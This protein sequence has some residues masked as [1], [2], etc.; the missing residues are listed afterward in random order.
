MFKNYFKVALR[1]IRRHPGYS[2][3]NIAG[4]AIGLAC[5]L[6]ILIWVLDELNYDKF[7]ENAPYL[8]RVEENQYYSGR[9]YHVTVTPYPLA[10]AIKADFPEIIE[11]TQYVGVGGQL[12][13][14]GEKAFFE[15]GIRAVAPAFFRMFTFPFVKG[16]SNTALDD[17][18]SLVISEEMAEKYFGEEDP[19]GKVFSVNNT[20][21]MKVSGVMKNIP[22]N[23]YLQFDM[24]IPY[25][26]LEKVGAV[27]DSMG[28]NSILT[29]VQLQ[30]GASLQ[31]INDKIR[32]F[33]KK[34][35]P[36]SV[37]DLE[38]ALYSKIHL[39]QYFGYGRDMGQI[40]YVYIFSVIALFVLMIACINFMNLSTARSANRAKEV[41]VRKVVGA[42]KSHIIRQFYGES[43][44]YA[45][46]ALVF[47]V[48]I[49]VLLMSPFN[50]L[51]GKEL[52]LGI[53][54]NWMILAGF[55]GVTLF[56]GLVAGSY[57]ALFL[58]SFQ[59]VWV[60]KGNLK[61]G[62]RSSLFRR[63]RGVVQFALSIF[64]IIGTV[65][66]YN[67][68]HYMKNR[69]IGYDKEHLV[70]IPMRGQ[71]GRFYEALKNA[72]VRDPRILNVTG[73]NHRPSNIGS[74]SGGA[75]WDG[76]DPDQVVLI[77]ISSVDYDYIE[78]I[79][80]ELKEGR[81]FSK[82][83]GTDQ[84]EAFIVNEEVAKLMGKESV[85]GENFSFAGRDGNIIGV[86]KNFHY[87]SVRNK[88]EPLAIYLRPA[89]QGF[90]YTLIR[91]APE[92][93]S[94]S[95]DF[96]KD[97]W[98]KVVPDFPF[99]Y[100]FLVEDF[101]YYYRSEERMGGLLKYFSIL[102]VFIACLG[103]FGLAS[104]TAEQ[105]TKEIGIRK[106]LGASASQITLLLCRE[107]FVLVLLAN[108]ISW[109]VAYFVMRNWL[110][111]FAYRT[112]LGMLTFVLTMVLALIIALLT[113]SFQAVKAAVANPVDALKYE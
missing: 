35:V 101:E 2:I 4:L 98:Q 112:S 82:E 26:L 18:F 21:D 77:G 111:D 6:F 41:G 11:A 29:F 45:F 55:I 15:T 87:Y 37:T 49:V 19:I 47:A 108:I 60:I 71:T 66:V 62:A 64:L 33:I 79:G 63:R 57:P 104:F 103:L 59:P 90:S 65:V 53:L 68:L 105:R 40:K 81:S 107:F 109:P 84:T 54:G 75:N 92:N 110:Q 113:V 73:S 96:V 102:A 99:E 14:Y 1:N 78:T 58:S 95:L 31:Q 25:A 10:P 20:Y 39:H 97:T 85:A 48:I 91:I 88:I 38:L 72:L 34:H 28:S 27:S 44:I 43:V 94:A 23:S 86:M 9:V 67:Q 32:G 22:N 61:S 70:Y 8:Y 13:R 5:C 51:S 56:T 76:K 69:D 80:I 24:V 46:I 42:L 12:I 3:I 93:I 52:S 7:H 36:D 17:P 106:V 30:K 83:Y 89:A 50:N 100:R 74:N 16:D